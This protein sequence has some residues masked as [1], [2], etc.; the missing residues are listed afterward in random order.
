MRRFIAC[1]ISAMKI[2]IAGTGKMGAAMAQRLASVGHELSVWNRTAEKTRPLAE[3]G[4]KVANV[5]ADLL[6]TNDVIISMLGDAAAVDSVYA[7]LFAASPQGKLFIEMS[8][9][10]PDVSRSLAAK[11]RARG[12]A[13]VECP[14]GGSVGPAKEGKL[15]GFVG[16]EPADLARARPI[17]EQ[18]CRRVEH[19][20]PVGSGASMKLAINLP[21]IVYWQALGEALC[22]IRGLNLDPTRVMD[23]LGDTSGAPA[24]LKNRAGTIAAALAGKENPNVTVDIDTLR[25]DL[26]EMVDEG[27]ALGR[28]LPVTERTLECFEQAS[29][30]GL[31]GKDCSSMPATWLRRAD[32]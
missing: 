19:L 15:F 22:L 14:V 27:R 31:G 18:L 28:M 32:H 3:A 7:Q 4:M 24:M 9:V 5:P 17:L 21:L 26:Q 11:A 29:R 6:K 16:A 1:S 23:I 30:A 25:K 10:R 13:F 2:G 20:G 8:T 12:A